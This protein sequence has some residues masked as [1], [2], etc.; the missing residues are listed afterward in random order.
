MSRREDAVDDGP[1]YDA[2][3][4]RLVVDPGDGEAL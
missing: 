1:A 3:V 2:A 4:G